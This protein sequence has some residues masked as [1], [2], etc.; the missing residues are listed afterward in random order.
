M[1]ELRGR[2]FNDNRP[3]WFKDR[4]ANSE[5]CNK[6]TSEIGFRLVIEGL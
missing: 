5:L 4:D 2:S 3:F 6:A 1:V